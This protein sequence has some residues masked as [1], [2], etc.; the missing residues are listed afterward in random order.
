MLI[1]RNIALPTRPKPATPGSAR[2]GK[3]KSLVAQMTPGDSVY[4]DDGRSATQFCRALNRNKMKSAF[5]PWSKGYR[6]WRVS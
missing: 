4:F 5:R 6:V 2:Y 1:E 3:L